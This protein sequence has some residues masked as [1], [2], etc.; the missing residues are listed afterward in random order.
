M[1]VAGTNGGT[2]QSVIFDMD[3][4]V[5]DSHPAHRRAW[6]E[7]L[8]TLG[9]K[10]SDEDLNY[11]LDGRKRSEILSHF[12]GELTALEI[13]EYG[14]RKDRFFQQVSLEVKPV[15]GVLDFLDQLREHKITAALA[16]SASESRTRSTLKQLKL[17]NYFK[18]VVTGND[19]A[20]GKPDPTIYRL[21]SQKLNVSPGNA[22]V[23]ED[24][25]AGIKA[26]KGAGIR[27]V[28][29]AGHQ[30]ADTLLEAG[31][32][33][34]IRDFMGFSVTQLKTVYQRHPCEEDAQRTLP[35]NHRDAKPSSRNARQPL[36]E[37][38]QMR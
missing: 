12:L 28:A 21:A 9:R 38:R 36:L 23:L 14:N 6:R 27:C 8:E 33:H 11:I 20:E 2:L 29:V 24:A 19:V 1:K 34:V 5:V 18:V 13:Q 31:A 7:F 32:D 17:S 16:T 4:V 22:L 37:R 35:M 3:G 10:V 15:H 26:A 25:V 30:S